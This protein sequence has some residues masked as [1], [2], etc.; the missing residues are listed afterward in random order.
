MILGCGGTTEGKI[1]ARLLEQHGY[2]FCYST[3]TET[4]FQPAGYRFGPFTEEGLKSFCETNNIKLI[5]H[6]S[7]PF[8]TE[9]HKTIYRSVNVPVL[10]F[11]RTYPE[12]IEHPLVRYL[13]NYEDALAYLEEYHVRLLALTGVQTIP[14]L[15]SY[16]QKHYTIFRI[17]PRES[18]I[19]L[20]LEA[21][22][23]R[24]NLLTEMPG[25]DIIHEMEIIGK[26]NIEGILTKESGE[27]G[28]LSVKLQV[29][30]RTGIPILIIKRPP[31]PETFIT[32]SDEQAL[33]DHLKHL[34]K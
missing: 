16:W 12:R 7:H 15:R 3:K 5:I 18:S 1:V 14:K 20:A 9:L 2:P 19:Q 25:D 10:R 28:F 24:D 6:A 4:D 30:L 33:L 17:L 23:S 22:F 32:V 34:L 21:G 29:A 26:Y 8:A 11:E 27:S 31:L 13:D